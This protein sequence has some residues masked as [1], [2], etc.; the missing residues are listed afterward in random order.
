[1]IS[2][3]HTELGF[4]FIHNNVCYRRIRLGFSYRDVDNVEDGTIF[5]AARVSGHTEKFEVDGDIKSDFSVCDSESYKEGRKHNENDK[6]YA[7]DET[8]RKEK[9]NGEDEDR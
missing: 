6:Q 5:G 4:R 7:D 1:L 3:F 8:D 9:M 2:L